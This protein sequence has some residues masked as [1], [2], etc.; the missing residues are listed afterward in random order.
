[1]SDLKDEG[2]A[3]IMNI[4]VRQEILNNGGPDIGV[5]GNNSQ[6]YIDSYNQHYVKGKDRDKAREEIG[7][8]FADG[9]RPS[10]DPNKTYREYY[11]ERF[12][13][14]YDNDGENP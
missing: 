1:M 11:S 14:H 7:K 10:T 2:E 6:K 13:E 5:A 9:E 8:V 12:E 3:T 4:K